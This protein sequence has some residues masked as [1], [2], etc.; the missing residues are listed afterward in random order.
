MNSSKLELI[1]RIDWSE[2]DLFGHINNVMISKYVQSARVN[3]WDKIGLSEMFRSQKI[4]ATVAATKV[5]F[6]QPLY[7]PGNIKIYTWIQDIKNTSFI[8]HHEIYN[9]SHEL[10]VYAEDVVVTYDYNAHHKV[11]LS[12]FIRE[13]YQKLFT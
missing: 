5:Q 7:Y 9:D 3:L 10:C 8:M 6:K 13:A 4:G 11:N 2:Q 1:L 12:E